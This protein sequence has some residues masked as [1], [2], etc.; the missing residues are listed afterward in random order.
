M[1][2]RDFGEQLT[3]VMRERAIASSEL[4]AAIN[5]LTQ[6]VM[7]WRRGV[8]IPAVASLSA[9]AVA[10]SCALIDLMPESARYR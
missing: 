5:V 10:M 9:M 4:A 7:A 3:A 1:L 8:S 6:T 2:C